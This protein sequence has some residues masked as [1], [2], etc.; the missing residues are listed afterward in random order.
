[1]SSCLN[2]P[3]K[4]CISGLSLTSDN[5]KEA[6]CILK[7]RYASPQVII[8]AHMEALVKLPVVKN[9]NNVVQLRK[10]YDLVESSMRNLISLKIM[11]GSYGALLVPVLTEKLPQEIKMIIARN[12]TN[13]I[14]DIELLME[15]FKVELQAKERCVSVG[16]NLEDDRQKDKKAEFTTSS[17]LGLNGK[18][19]CVYCRQSHPSSKCQKITNVQA[20][21]TILRKYARCFICLKKGHISR[22]CKSEYKCHK[23]SN[24]HHIS[25]CDGDHEKN[26][27]P[28]NESHT[29][30]NGNKNNILLQTAIGQ[31]A[32][33]GSDRYVSAKIMLDSGS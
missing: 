11:P 9:D 2:G 25:L 19:V 33:V 4:D 24:R 13:D 23:C 14:W 7:E 28:V 5:Y 22:D 26:D 29:N 31:V 18:I 6:I 21:R 17:F 15:Y 27:E 10:M 30:F 32:S 8:S 12:F 3:A 16:L 1:M 20:R